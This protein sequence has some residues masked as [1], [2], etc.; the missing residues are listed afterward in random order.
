MELAVS[1]SPSAVFNPEKDVFVD[2][3]KVHMKWAKQKSI[4]PDGSGRYLKY[5]HTR[6]LPNKDCQRA[7]DYIAALVKVYPVQLRFAMAAPLWARFCEAY[8]DFG[9]IDAALNA[10]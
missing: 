1:Q 2:N 5:Q 4:N 3:P 6:P 8:C 9:D 7:L 10:I